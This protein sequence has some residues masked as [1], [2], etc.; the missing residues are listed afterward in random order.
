MDI[1]AAKPVSSVSAAPAV[2]EK[3]SSSVGTQGTATT[4]PARER[5]PPPVAQDIQHR[6]AVVAEQLQKFLRS[7][8]RDLEF[9]VDGAADTTVITVRDASTG[10][11]I[12]QIPSEEALRIMRRLN[13]ESGT[14]LNLIA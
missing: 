10:D 7:T 9:S 4:T 8:D 2:P 13:A 12:R 6:L 1:K 3:Q 5:Q 11:V 14:L